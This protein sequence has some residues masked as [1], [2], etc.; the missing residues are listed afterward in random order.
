VRNLEGARANGARVFKFMKV[1]ESESEEWLLKSLSM[2][3]IS[4]T[5]STA[6]AS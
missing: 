5:S 2:V 3:E 1:S 4:S 6:E